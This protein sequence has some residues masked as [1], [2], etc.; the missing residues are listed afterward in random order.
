MSA[1]WIWH[2]N[3]AHSAELAMIISYPTS[4]GEMT[5][6]LKRPPKNKKLN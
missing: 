5:V 6:L 1:C 3:E 4:A 2:D